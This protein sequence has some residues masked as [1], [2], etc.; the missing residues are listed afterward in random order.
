MW[1]SSMLTVILLWNCSMPAGMF[2]PCIYFAFVVLHKEV[3]MW[4]GYVMGSEHVDPFSLIDLA[5]P[6]SARKPFPYSVIL[7]L[8]SVFCGFSVFMLHSYQ[9][10]DRSLD[11][12]Y[13]A[14]TFPCRSFFLGPGIAYIALP[15][16]P[17]P[18][19]RRFSVYRVGKIPTMRLYFECSL[20]K[21]ISPWLIIH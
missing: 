20:G 10:L 8:L 9:P 14:V 13:L 3:N 19:C 2:T 5:F 1:E 15:Y 4:S 12:S 11:M 6:S 16:S 18:H 7:I 21:P 17:P